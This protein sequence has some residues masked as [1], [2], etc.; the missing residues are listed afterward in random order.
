MEP[1]PHIVHN[2]NM[3]KALMF[4]VYDRYDRW[5]WRCFVEGW[6][7]G[8]L[9]GWLG[10]WFSNEYVDHVKDFPFACPPSIYSALLHRRRRD[11][12]YSRSICPP[13]IIP[14]VGGSSAGEYLQHIINQYTTKATDGQRQLKRGTGFGEI[15]SR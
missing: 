7:D 8:W 11:V 1:R 2:N 4:S 12:L 3:W 13:H 10:C 9:A 6:M 5:W 14:C 15:Y